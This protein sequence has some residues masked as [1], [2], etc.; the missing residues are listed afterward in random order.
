MTKKK[1]TNNKK[2]KITNRFET[3]SL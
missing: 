1:N 3:M 2:I